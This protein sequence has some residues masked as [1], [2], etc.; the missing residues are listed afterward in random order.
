MR[1]SLFYLPLATCALFSEAFSQTKR[2]E[3]NQGKL[4]LA[5]RQQDPIMNIPIPGFG[6]GKQDSSADAGNLIISDVIGKDRVINIFAGFTRDIDTISKRLDDVTKNTTVLAP[7]NSEIQK[8]PRKP[9]EDPKDYGSLGESAYDGSDGEDRAHRNLRRFVESH[10]IPTSPW[11]EGEKIKSLGGE[12]LWWESKQGTR[13]VGPRTWW[14]QYR[15]VANATQIQPG[16]IEVSSI[17]D[18]VS[19]GEVW[20]LKGV[21]NY[22]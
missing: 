13:T 20:V 1:T 9:W 16:N 3:R 2:E 7:L 19:N 5:D 17:A 12:E 22:A 15:H 10:V 21:V 18:K 11:K 4:S 6:G 8:L 14:W